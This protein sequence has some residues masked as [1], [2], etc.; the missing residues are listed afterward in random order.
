[1]ERVQRIRAAAAE[2]KAKNVEAAPPDQSGA[3]VLAHPTALRC[4]RR[5]DDA[6]GA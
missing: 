3:L 5:K 1:L 2:Q 4:T 6:H